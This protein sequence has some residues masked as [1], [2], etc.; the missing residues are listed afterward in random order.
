MK[1]K[2]DY[3]SPN[4][5]VVEFAMHEIIAASINQSISGDFFNDSLGN[6]TE[7]DWD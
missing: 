7:T 5:E 3:A 4:L 6:N 1:K 2:K